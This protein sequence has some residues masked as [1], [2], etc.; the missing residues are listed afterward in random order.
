MGME[1]GNENRKG[2]F[3]SILVHLEFD[4]EYVNPLFACKKMEYE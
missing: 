2:Q 1:I 4:W 3:Q